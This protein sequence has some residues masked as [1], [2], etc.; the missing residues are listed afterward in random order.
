[1]SGSIE[2]IRPVFEQL[3]RHM[4]D[5]VNGVQDGKEIRKSAFER[6]EQ[7]SKQL[8]A[9]LKGQELLPRYI[10]LQLS[11]AATILQNEASYMLTTADKQEALRMASA[12]KLTLDSILRGECHEDR[13]PGIPRII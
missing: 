10:L 8:T 12:I 3:E 1:M 11:Q 5:V 6:T 13:R 9:L 2:E 7:L 4:L